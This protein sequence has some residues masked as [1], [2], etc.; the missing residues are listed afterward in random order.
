MAYPRKNTGA[1]SNGFMGA[2]KGDGTSR[3][4]PTPPLA[5]SISSLTKRK[6][7]RRRAFFVSGRL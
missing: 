7:N 1:S 2:N 4:M 6:V 5:S 3:W